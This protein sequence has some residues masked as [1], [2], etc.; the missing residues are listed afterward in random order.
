MAMH[1][2]LNENH[3]ANPLM[4]AVTSDHC[5]Q[6]TRQANTSADICHT[7]RLSGGKV[8]CKFIPDVL[9]GFCSGQ[10]KRSDSEVLLSPLF[11]PL[12][13][14]DHCDKD[15]TPNVTNIISSVVFFE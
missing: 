15:L 4:T 11:L 5:H 6:N 3:R 10:D 14:K 2:G 12:S 1:A 8:C 7:E 13:Y 9:N